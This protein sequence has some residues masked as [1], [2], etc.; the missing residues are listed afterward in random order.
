MIPRSLGERG[1]AMELR[2]RS[3]LH[4]VQGREKLFQGKDFSCTGECW[5]FQWRDPR[6]G[7]SK[8]KSLAQ[9]TQL[10]QHGESGGA[11]GRERGRQR[12]WG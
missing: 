12:G 11:G 5:P 2:E 3:Y 1:A 8:Q 7:L 4:A 10:R 6:D 9:T